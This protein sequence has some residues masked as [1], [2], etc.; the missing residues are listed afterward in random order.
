MIQCSV[1]FK[2]DTTLKKGNLGK[3]G[4]LTHIIPV[5]HSHKSLSNDLV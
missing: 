1:P 2:I 4:T 3:L 5:T